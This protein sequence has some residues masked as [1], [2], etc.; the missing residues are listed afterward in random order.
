M[1]LLER[2]AATRCSVQGCNE[3]RS[4]DSDVCSEDLTRKWRHLLARQPDGTYL[5]R[6]ELGARDLTGRLRGAAA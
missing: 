1:G 6:R 5:R 2:M 3:E 4:P